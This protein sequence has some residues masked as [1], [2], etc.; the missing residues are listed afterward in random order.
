MEGA[1][2]E[3][4]SVVTAVPALCTERLVLRP[5]EPSDAARVRE[6]A[7]APEV[8][9]TTGN[10]PH[11]YPEGAAEAWIAT[12]A[13]RAAAGEGYVWAVT[14]A[15]DSELLG[16]VGIHPVRQHSR[17]EI[18]YWLGVPYWNR[19]YMTEAA[20]RVVAW[21]FSELGLN[22]IQIRCFPRNVGSSRVALKVGMQYEGTLR[23]YA[24]KG[25]RYEDI[26]V[27]GLLRGDPAGGAQD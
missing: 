8:A 24:R 22:R 20:R 17:A 9:A 1:S 10:I 12:H 2:G 5:F 26:A 7:G 18:G 4:A 25:D 21:G 11:P 6:L 19:G 15:E 3:D 27:Y 13:D 16:A 23:A 14:L